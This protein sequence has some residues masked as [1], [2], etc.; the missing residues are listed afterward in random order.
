MNNDL[1]QSINRASQV[2]DAIHQSR[3]V[4]DALG[5]MLGK[6]P[7]SS[8]PNRQSNDYDVSPWSRAGILRAPTVMGAV[9]CGVLP[10]IARDVP[11]ELTVLIEGRKS[12]TDSPYIEIYALLQDTFVLSTKSEW[13]PFNPLGDIIPEEVKALGAAFGKSFQTRVSSRRFWKGTEPLDLKIELKFEAYKDTYKEVVEPCMNL[14][15]LALPSGGM[16]GQYNLL[17]PP[18][19]NPFTLKSEQATR[20]ELITIYIG[21]FLVFES[22]VVKDVSTTFS[23][24]IARNG[25]PV[26]ASTT[27]TFQT[28]EVYTKEMLQTAYHGGTKGGRTG[29]PSVI[30][31]V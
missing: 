17:T 6:K 31:G 1:S 14:Q 22:V 19:P 26:S 29:A 2:A 18:G 15:K 23:D 4:M 24:R 5:T 25:H 9:K 3:E 30:G 20:G 21:R 11:S 16:F 10:E 28:Y 8:Q 7:Q 12:P 13:E 27:I